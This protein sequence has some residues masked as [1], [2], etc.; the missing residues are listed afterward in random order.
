MLKRMMGRHVEGVHRIG[1]ESR[2]GRI[3]AMTQINLH[4]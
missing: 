4:E 2:R 1:T 3:D